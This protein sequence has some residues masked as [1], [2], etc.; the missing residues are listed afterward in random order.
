MAMHSEAVKYLL[1]LIHEGGIDKSQI[2][3]LWTEVI[4]SESCSQPLHDEELAEDDTFYA[5]GGGWDEISYDSD[6]DDDS[7]DSDDDDIDHAV[8][9]TATGDTAPDVD[10][11]S[12]D[13]DDD[14]DD[15]DDP[16]YD[17]DSTTD[18]RKFVMSV[19]RM[20]NAAPFVH[21]RYKQCTET[22]II[23]V[24][25]MG[26]T[27]KCVKKKKLYFSPDRRNQ[28]NQ[29]KEG[30]IVY[31]KNAKNPRKAVYRK[32]RVIC[33]F[34]KINDLSESLFNKDVIHKLLKEGVCVKYG[35]RTDEWFDSMID[36]EYHCK[37]E[38]I[39]GEKTLAYSEVRDS[40]WHWLHNPVEHCCGTV[41]QMRKVRHT[42]W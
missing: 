21:E 1:T 29:V 33:E 15:S 19:A 11:I 27:E 20:E 22:D 2:D 24:C 7:D 38:W 40:M 17:P 10:E 36:Y 26:S 12:S 23:S 34:K 35:K 6:D 18:T 4:Q 9:H 32:G 28:I 14:D 16:E 39:E 37:V 8:A 31:V 41:R 5:G 30:D 25:V 3:A 42:K 13:S